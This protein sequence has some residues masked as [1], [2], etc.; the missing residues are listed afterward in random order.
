ME[1]GQNKL[2]QG[3]EVNIGIDIRKQQPNEKC[4]R[5][6]GSEILAPQNGEEGE[7]EMHARKTVP[8]M[9]MTWMI[10]GHSVLP[11]LPA[12]SHLCMKNCA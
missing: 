12:G 4:P 1:A 2:R 5:F 8:F 6:S 9:L 7:V 10:F 11:L 3:R